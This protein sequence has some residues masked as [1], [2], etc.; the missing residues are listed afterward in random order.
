M[1]VETY[2][3]GERGGRVGRREGG[4]VV[5]YSLYDDGYLALT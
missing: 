5:F 4:K 3:E 2:R 1:G